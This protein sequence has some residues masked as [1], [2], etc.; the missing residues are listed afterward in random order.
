MQGLENVYSAIAEEE[1]EEAVDDSSGQ[2]K[3]P[4]PDARSQ[5]TVQADLL[6]GALGGVLGA[7]AGGA[8][9]ETSEERKK[10]K[11]AAIVMGKLKGQISKETA[12]RCGGCARLL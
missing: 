8:D 11:E 7:S 4:R 6:K 9:P 2:H 3:M 12:V 10:S 1:E 5:G